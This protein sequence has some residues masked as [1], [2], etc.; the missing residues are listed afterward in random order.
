MLGVGR[1]GP[2]GASAD[3]APMGSSGAS[4]RP[5]PTGASAR[6]EHSDASSRPS[7]RPAGG[8]D[9][10]SRPASRGSRSARAGAERLAWAVLASVDGLGPIGLVGLVLRWGDAC[11]A[12]RAAG[13]PG[14]AALIARTLGPGSGSAALADRI[15][16]AARDADV[17]DASL[18]A[19]GVQVMTLDDPAYPAPLA[20]I[21]LPPPVLF[22]RGSVE[23]LAADRLVAI[24]GTRRPTAA[25]RHHAARLAAGVARAG[26]VVVSGLAVGIDG[27]AHAATLG[28][29]GTTVAVIGGG[30]ARAIPRSHEHLA[31]AI[32]D[33]GG[34][35]VSEHA[36]GTSPSRGTFPRRNRVISGL[37]EATVVVEAGVRSGALITAGWAL[38]QGRDCFVV[39]GPIDAPAS[40]GCL[41]LLRTY[42]G[43]VRVVAGVAEL[44]EDLAL[45]G[46]SPPSISGDHPGRITGPSGSIGGPSAAA[47]LAGL[48]GAVADV[49]RALADGPRTADQLVATCGLPV[50]S[51]LAALTVLEDRGLA[52]GGYGRYHLAG[53][54]VGAELGG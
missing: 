22:V 15:A 45:V 54:L 24:V 21:E 10:A 30:H 7:S 43:Q 6:P 48:P 4:A 14:G 1:A 16:A 31:V 25:G 37:S 28:V 53:P 41:A 32:V 11:G 47:I 46:G 23:A 19:A 35:V 39:P 13:R 50:A 36:P 49:A 52:T 12:V 33:G 26:A 17:I 8:S 40:A 44:I 9:D 20:R 18:R 2:V 42:A 29:G 38:E 27:V 51:I 3:A 34:A 5:E